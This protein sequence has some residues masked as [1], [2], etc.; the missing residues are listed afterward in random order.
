MQ[1]SVWAVTIDV[2]RIN[3]AGDAKANRK[4]QGRPDGEG[5]SWGDRPLMLTSGRC[6]W[7]FR[8]VATRTA[9]SPA[10]GTPM[11]ESAG[12]P[13]R[14]AASLMRLSCQASVHK[15]CSGPVQSTFRDSPELKTN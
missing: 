5:F 4:K 14:Q 7:Y 12:P 1:R 2:D 13:R 3:L 6:G 10:S 15:I 11:G 8:V 9:P